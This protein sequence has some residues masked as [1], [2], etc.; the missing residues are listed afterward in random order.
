[1]LQKSSPPLKH[2][3]SLVGQLYS[4]YLVWP[5]LTLK[6]IGHRVK[7]ELSHQYH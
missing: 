7:V 1:M 3:V 2:L 4:G 5:L 6:R